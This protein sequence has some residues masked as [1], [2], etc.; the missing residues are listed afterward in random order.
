MPSTGQYHIALT[1]HASN[2][3][4]WNRVGIGHDCAIFIFD[5]LNEL[6]QSFWQRLILKTV[7]DRDKLEY[8]SAKQ[9]II[10]MLG[11]T[12]HKAMCY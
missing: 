8:V 7:Y 10:R 12:S 1:K 4:F 11:H 3:I 6:F 5:S 2:N 9:S